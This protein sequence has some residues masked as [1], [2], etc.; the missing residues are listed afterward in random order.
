[1]ACIFAWLEA[2]ALP[3]SVLGYVLRDLRI[4]DSHR[5]WKKS[6][7]LEQLIR[8]LTAR[9]KSF[10]SPPLELGM[11]SVLDLEFGKPIHR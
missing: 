9:Y 2:D 1:M 3:A 4:T 5:R 8:M 7:S 10:S 6:P 11:F